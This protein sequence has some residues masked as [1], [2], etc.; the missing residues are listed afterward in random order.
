MNR[1]A[2]KRGSGA[3]GAFASKS[4]RGAGR[5]GLVYRKSQND[6]EK[7]GSEAIASLMR[8]TEFDTHIKLHRKE[9]RRDCYITLAVLV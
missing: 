1:H 4:G 2:V 8:H 6:Q 3:S 7:R 5:E 9:T